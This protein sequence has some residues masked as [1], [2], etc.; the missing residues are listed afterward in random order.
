MRL[1]AASVTVIARH[2]ADALPAGAREVEAAS[3]E[4]VEFV[5]SAEAKKVK[6]DKAG[7]ATGV[8]CVAVAPG[9]D[10]KL[11]PERGSAFVVPATSV[12]T[13]PDYTPDVGD[14]D[15]ELGFSAWGTLEADPFTGRTQTPG[16]FA[17]G[18]A[19]VG[20]QV[21]DPRGRGRQARRPGDR[22]PGLPATTST[23]SKPT[24]RSTP[25]CP[26]SSS[27]TTQRS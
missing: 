27:S 10:G 14:S 25:A 17:G 18:D 3:D 2:A 15:E 26:I 13:A 24:W 16:V 21:G 22:A 9:P 8:E 20:R 19:G 5:Y 12:I 6:A 4:G 11:R 23:R 7:K 1:G